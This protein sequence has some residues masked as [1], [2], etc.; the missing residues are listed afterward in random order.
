MNTKIVNQLSIG[1][2]INEL[3]Y[4]NTWIPGMKGGKI[5]WVVGGVNG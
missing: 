5:G 1:W 3:A 2:K 4:D